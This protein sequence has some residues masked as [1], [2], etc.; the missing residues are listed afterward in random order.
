MDVVFED[1]GVG[2]LESQKILVPRLQSLQFVLRVLRLPLGEKHTLSAK[3]KHYPADRKM[4]CQ[5]PVS[6]DSGIL[7]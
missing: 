5:F 7:L 4:N 6:L 2:G 1:G 3:R